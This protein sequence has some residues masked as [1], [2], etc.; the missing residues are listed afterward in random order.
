MATRNTKQSKTT[1][2]MLEKMTANLK[3]TIAE[4]QDRRSEI[5]FRSHQEKRSQSHSMRR[6]TAILTAMMRIY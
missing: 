3:Q 5:Q 6:D 2:A 1:K 4:K